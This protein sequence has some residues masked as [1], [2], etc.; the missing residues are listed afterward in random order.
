MRRDE[1]NPRSS[2]GMPTQR[3]ADLAELFSE[4]ITLEPER[5]A[6]RLREACGE[7][8]ELRAELS[9][10]VSAHESSGPLDSAADVV[11]LLSSGP[12]TSAE[13]RSAALLGTGAGDRVGPYRL[14]RPL[15]EGGV[16]SVWC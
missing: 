10:L 14:G 4:L 11:G 7:D 5:R 12:E 3:W 2:R 9:S 13:E 1:H 8:Q 15:G 16:G 6:A